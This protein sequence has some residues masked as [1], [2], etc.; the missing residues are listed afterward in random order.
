MSQEEKSVSQL[1][2]QLGEFRSEMIQRFE[3]V[4][5]RFEQVD[6]RFEQVDKRFEQVDKRFEQVD[7]RFEQVDKRFEQGDKRIST[8][9]RSIEILSYQVGVLTKQMADRP[10]RAEFIAMED[11]IVN[12]VEER[13]VTRVCKHIDA[14]FEQFSIRIGVV[15]EKYQDLPP[16]VGRLREDLDRHVVD[17][18][19]H[20]LGA[21]TDP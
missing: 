6:K 19:M 17:S 7:K 15:D 12:N 14:A 1:S 18:S 4:D 10:T 2:A 5:K 9:E 16:K 20:S 8:A 13:V 21:V 3:Q 11:R